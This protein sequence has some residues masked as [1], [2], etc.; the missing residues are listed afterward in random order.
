MMDSSKSNAVCLMGPNCDCHVPCFSISDKYICVVMRKRVAYELYDPALSIDDNA[1]MLGCSVAS[2]RKHFS[3]E[4]IDRR[5][6]VQYR[7]W[8]Q[9]NRYY[10][11]NPESSLRTASAELHCSINT[12]RKYR[13]MTEDEFRVSIRDTSKVSYFDI[14]NRNCI[15][16][17]SYSQDEILGWIMA[18]YNNRQPFDCDLTASLCVF[19]RRLPLPAHLYDIS[20]QMAEV[21]PLAEADRLPD[22][23]FDSV[24]Y[25]LPFIISPPKT[26]NTIKDRFTYFKSEDEARSVNIAMLNRAFRLL[27]TGG[28]LVVKTMDCVVRN[29]QCWISDFVVQ[30][31]AKIGLVMADK[32]IL[33]SHYRLLSRT[34]QQHIARKYHSYFFVFRKHHAK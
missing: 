23:S 21:R 11:D 24:I 20:P 5:Y 31:A 8:R 15:K 25:D 4:G 28:I 22:C 13:A 32:F 3:K 14:Q 27:R 1:A 2:L 30:E 7:R 34:K 19:W 6:D 29:R 17:I 9:V 16:S 33:L 26:D 10:R 12:V 18:M